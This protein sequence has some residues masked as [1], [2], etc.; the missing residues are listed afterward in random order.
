MHGPF[1]RFRHGGRIPWPWKMA[2]ALVLIPGFIFL[3]PWIIMLLWNALMPVIFGI[4]VISF[5]Q[6]MGL[7]VLAKL[8]FGGFGGHGGRSHFPRKPQYKD[9]EAWKEHMREQFGSFNQD[10]DNVK[11][12]G[13]ETDL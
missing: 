12:G 5:W 11:G 9:R 4:T 7:I 2:G 8:L 3:G 10:N 13:S 1:S 6:S